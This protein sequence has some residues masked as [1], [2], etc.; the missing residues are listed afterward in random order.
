MYA[1]EHNEPRDIIPRA[2]PSRPNSNY[3]SSSVGLDDPTSPHHSSAV[4]ALRSLTVHPPSPPSPLG[5]Q[6]GIWPFSKSAATSPSTSYGKGGSAFFSSTYD[7]GYGAPGYGYNYTNGMDR[8]LPT[9]NP[10]GYSRPKSIE[11]VTPMLGR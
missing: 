5:A 1:T 6:S 4:S 8:P 7:G 2:S 9:R 10:S 3:Y 11:L